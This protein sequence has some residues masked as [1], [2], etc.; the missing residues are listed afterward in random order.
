MD[1]INDHGHI[2]RSIDNRLK[3]LENENSELSMVKSQR[4]LLKPVLH[5]LCSSSK[6]IYLVPVSYIVKERLATKKARDKV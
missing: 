5:V 1:V 6:G 4:K 3:T 2:A